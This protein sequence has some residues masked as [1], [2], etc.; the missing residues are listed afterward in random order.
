M[1][2]FLFYAGKDESLRKHRWPLI[3][4]KFVFWGRVI[5]LAT[6]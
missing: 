1:L 5:T 3:Q 4:P 6:E 2:Y